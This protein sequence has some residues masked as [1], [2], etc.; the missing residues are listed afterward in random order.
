MKVLI[1]VKNVKYA[2]KFLFVLSLFFFLIC[3]LCLKKIRSGSEVF[4]PQRAL[5]TPRPDLSSGS[6]SVV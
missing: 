6:V 5:D 4:E 1:H 2:T 3:Q